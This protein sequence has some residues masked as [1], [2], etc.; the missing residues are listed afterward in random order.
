M[1]AYQT[2]PTDIVISHIKNDSSNPLMWNI[3]DNEA[4]AKGVAK[5][6]KRCERSEAN[7]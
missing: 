3:Q 1:A 5:L 4:H 2:I 6:V 7:Q